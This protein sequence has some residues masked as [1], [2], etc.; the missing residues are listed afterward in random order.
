MSA[1]KP[2]RGKAKPPE[3][4]PEPPAH[5]S[6]RS[7]TLWRTLGPLHAENEGRRVMFATALECLDRMDEA[8]AA[9]ARDGLFQGSGKMQHLHPAATLEKE[10]RREAMKL[11]AALHLNWIDSEF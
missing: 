2:Y 3:S 7:K 5:L 4:Y 8:R 1:Y 6:E 11:W 10:S 9:I